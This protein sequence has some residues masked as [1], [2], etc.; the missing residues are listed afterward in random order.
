MSFSGFS[1]KI[2]R[3]KRTVV[4]LR[5]SGDGC[6]TNATT[7]LSKGILPRA[8]GLAE[9]GTERSINNNS[10]NE[11]VKHLVGSEEAVTG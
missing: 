4:I 6:R 8:N 11:G 2:S 3:N 9:I 7:K 5:K 1:I 10:Q